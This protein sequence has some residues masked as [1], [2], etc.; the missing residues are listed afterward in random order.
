[1]LNGNERNTISCFTEKQQTPKNIE[2]RNSLVCNKNCVFHSFRPSVI[3]YSDILKRKN[4][5]NQ[6]TNLTY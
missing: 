1:M 6:I 3:Q 5:S 2:F 4:L